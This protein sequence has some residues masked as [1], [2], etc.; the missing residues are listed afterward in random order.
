MRTIIV[1]TERSIVNDNSLPFLITF[2]IYR[3]TIEVSIDLNHTVSET[4][5][6]EAFH[7]IV[8]PLTFKLTAV[9]PSELSIAV[10][11]T[12]AELSHKP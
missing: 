1:I 9:S 12:S 8:F 4:L 3:V 6:A 7:F 5:G 10:E 11:H 2:S